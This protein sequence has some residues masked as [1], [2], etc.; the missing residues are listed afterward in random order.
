[1]ICIGIHLGKLHANRKFDRIFTIELVNV[2]FNCKLKENFAK[3][4]YNS[5]YQVCNSLA[6][7]TFSECLN[8]RAISSLA[9]KL[10]NHFLASYSKPYRSI[11]KQ[12]LKANDE[13]LMKKG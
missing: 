6:C 2:N 3:G 11:K 1:M 13:L 12:F 8:M 10:A 7:L 4:L 9:G 5:V